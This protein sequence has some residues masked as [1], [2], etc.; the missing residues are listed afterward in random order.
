[1]TKAM[2]ALALLGCTALTACGSKDS[3]AD[4]S[5]D[6][7]APGDEAGAG[8]GGGISADVT[9]TGGK[10]PGTYKG[11]RGSI[12]CIDY[13]AL[14][15]G[16]QYSRN[17]EDTTSGKLG[18]AD[19]GTKSKAAAPTDDFSMSVY[20]S[21]PRMDGDFAIDPKKGNGTGTVRV[22]GTAPNYVVA[23]SGKTADGVGVEAT[24]RCLQ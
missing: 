16:G 13:G 8:A 12:P 21:S 2:I 5:G 10:Y 20:I 24:F 7:A 14:G 3:A 1:M 19:F 11:E 4:S 23:I 17:I 9:L 15:L 22:T 18:R 6:A